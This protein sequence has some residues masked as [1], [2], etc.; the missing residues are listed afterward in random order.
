M[1]KT[2]EEVIQEKSE[3]WTAR[4][5]SDL[6]VLLPRFLK[7]THVVHSSIGSEGAEINRFCI[8]RSKH[9]DLL[10]SISFSKDVEFRVAIGA[11]FIHEDLIKLKKNTP[12]H[13][14]NWA[15]PYLPLCSLNYHQVNLY[16]YS[17]PHVAIT[18]N[19]VSL[20]EPTRSEVVDLHHIF[21]SCENR[22]ISIS[23]GMGGV[24]YQEK[25]SDMTPPF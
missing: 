13:L 17:K 14:G 25:S 19:Y 24:V 1:S 16:L 2:L 20:P 10:H 6:P 9:F 5:N 23:G 8:P 11:N 18:V 22:A 7:P 4:M 15:T 3:Q 21:W 12:F